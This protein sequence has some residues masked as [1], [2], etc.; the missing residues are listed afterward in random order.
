[1]SSAIGK[2]IHGTFRAKCSPMLDEVCSPL[3][4]GGRRG[5]PVQVATHA[6]RA[7]Q[8][9]NLARRRPC[10]ILYVDLREAFHRVVRPL[11]HGG[12]L[13]DHHLAGIVKELGL[14]PDTIPRLH[15]YAR[16]QSLLRDAG[17][18]EWTSCIMKEISDDSWFT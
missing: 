11:I 10:A 1:M 3:Q 17:A 12:T 18:T 5:Q 13:S 7:F 4:I 15:E 9:A 8:S 2:S 6:V 16:F 14:G